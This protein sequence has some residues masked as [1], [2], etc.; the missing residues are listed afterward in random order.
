MENIWKIYNLP[1]NASPQENLAPSKTKSDSDEEVSKMMTR[2]SLKSRFSKRRY[3]LLE[4]LSGPKR[5]QFGQQ[6]EQ[7]Q[8]FD[9][10]DAPSV[11]IYEVFVSHEEVLDTISQMK[12]YSMLS[13]NGDKPIGK[14]PSN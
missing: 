2:I 10:R 13:T 9:H 4:I 11:N 6:L 14:H 5:V 1:E 12:E 8:V 3:H 7:V